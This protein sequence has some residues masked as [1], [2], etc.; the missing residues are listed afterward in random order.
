[1]NIPKVMGILIIGILI[2]FLLGIICIKKKN[3]DNFT[4]VED[5]INEITINDKFFLNL[6]VDENVKKV[7]GCSDFGKEMKLC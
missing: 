6:K 5:D 7:W 1:M 4:V 3:N 2:G